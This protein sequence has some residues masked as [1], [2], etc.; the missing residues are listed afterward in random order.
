MSRP[1]C[2]VLGLSFGL[3]AAGSL[4]AQTLGP[5]FASLYS[6]HDLGGVP[7]VPA[8]YGGLTFLRGNSN[9][10]LI[11]GAANGGAGR[12]YQTT[13]TRDAMGHI[14]GFSAAVDYC[15]GS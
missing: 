3:G 7:S 5:E 10:L 4:H 12:T 15:D 14:T 6:L 2:L 1:L 11:G 13:L 8:N 9:V